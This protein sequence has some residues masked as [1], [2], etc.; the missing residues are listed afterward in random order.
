MADEDGF[1]WYGVRCVFR[2]DSRPQAYEERITL[3]YADSIDRA[4]ELAE[5]E[6]GEYAAGGGF[7]YLAIA[8]AYR[9]FDR[10]G[11]GAE[12]FSLLR[13]SPLE[14]DDYLDSYFDTGAERQQNSD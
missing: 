14:P 2:W 7:E 8:Q 3:W 9:M 4:I 1:G 5:A 10:P 13:E 11:S 12:V 6:A